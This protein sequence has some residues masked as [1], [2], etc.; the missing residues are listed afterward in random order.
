MVD[1]L[2]VNELSKVRPLFKALDFHLGLLSVLDGTAPGRVFVDD[3]DEP[4]SAL[5]RR[6]RRF[7]LA[8]AAHNPAFIAD[9]RRL[10]CEQVYP[11]AQQAGEIE[12]VVYFDR[13]DWEAGIR[14]M[15]Q[16]RPPMRFQR[17]YYEFKQARQDWRSLVFPG[18][19]V[20]PVDT[21]L[22]K[23]GNLKHLDELKAEMVSE[24]P[25]IEAFLESQFGACAVVEGEIA[26]WCLSEYSHGGRC[27]VGIETVDSFRQ[28][29]IGTILSGALVEQALARGIRQ[30][31][32]DC[33]AGNL[34]SAATA[35]KAGF[36]KVRD[37]AVFLAWFDIIK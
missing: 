24:C 25:T 35:L 16:E 14:E 23:E 13:P 18:L 29:G 7:Y 31:G 32:W 1:E 36:E 17:Q 21:E 30:I 4:E 37:D 5:L 19:T 27:E 9:L 26:G 10:F 12:F 2:Q 20:R 34:P 28:R 8:G 33:Y 6:G 15:L 11:Q 22:L 3:A